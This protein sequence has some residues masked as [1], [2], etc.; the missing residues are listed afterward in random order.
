M[1]LSSIELWQRIAAEGLASPMQCRTWAAEAAKSLPAAETTDGIKV[2]QQLIEIGRLT[3]YQ[4][5]IL[6]GQSDRPLRRGSWHIL[7]RLKDPIWQ[8]WTEVT[9]IDTTKAEWDPP[10]W[11]RWLQVDDLDSLRASA[12]SL[13]RGIQMA[14][15]QHDHLQSVSIPELAD[16]ELHV[17]VGPLRGQVLTAQF[18][19]NVAPS[20]VAVQIVEQVASGLAALHAANLLHG[21][22]LPDRVFW[23]GQQSVLARDPLASWT[24]TLDEQAVGLLGHQLGDLRTASFLAPEFIA[25]GQPPTRCTDVYA[26]GCVW[27]W[28][29]T[30]KPPAI[31][32]NTQE[33]LAQQAQP[34]P[35]LPDSASL[36]EPM[37]KVLWH[38]LARN[39][40]SRFPDAS[41]LVKAILAAKEVIKLGK[42]TIAP[43]PSSRTNPATTSTKSHSTAQSGST[44]QSSSSSQPSTRTTKRASSRKQ[45]LSTDPVEAQSSVDSSVDKPVV[46]AKPV[47]SAAEKTSKRDVRSKGE[48]K[49]A[50]PAGGSAKT[51]DRGQVD[52]PDESAR[53]NE[54]RRDDE[55]AT[56]PQSS[57]S[58]A[59]T[60]ESGKPAET[61]SGDAARTAPQQAA[62]ATATD[63]A[64]AGR[65]GVAAGPPTATR[66]RPLQR[67]RRSKNK[68]MLPV[69][70]GAGFLI[71]LLLAL[72]FSGALDPADAPRETTPKP[73]PVAID[74]TAPGDVQRS[75]PRLDFYRIVDTEQHGLWAP[76]SAPSALPIDLLPPGGQCFVSL[77]P[78]E[79]LV[80]AAK[81]QLVAAFDPEVTRM[82]ES[83]SG[84]TGLPLETMAQVTVAF[85]SPIQSGAF[86]EW[87]VRVQLTQAQSLTQLKRQWSDPAAETV[88]QHQLLVNQSQ[89]AFYV[90]QQPLVDAQSVSTFSVGPLSLMRDVAELEGAGGPLV[91]QME[92]LWNATDRQA[93][94]AVL[95]APPYLFTEGRGLLA[96]SPPRLRSVL[97]DMLGQDMRAGLVQMHLEPSWYTELQLIGASDQ[98]AGRIAAELE[99]QAG[100]LP[101]EIEGWF[102]GQTPHAHWSRLALRYPQML[103]TLN[104]YSRFGVERGVA[105]SNAYLPT[106]AA[107][108]LLLASWIAMQESATLAGNSASPA[109]A[110][111]LAPLTVQQYLARPV[112]VSFAQEPIE[113]AWQM[114]GEEANDQL[115]AGT[116]TMRFELDG[117]AFELAG[118][119]RNQQL[120][121]FDMRNRPLREVLTQV[122]KMGN[123]VTTVTDT[124]DADQKLIWV[125]KADPQATGQSMISLTTRAAAT[126]SG[127]RLPEEFSPK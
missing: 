59:D 14:G 65:Q 57:G 78:A 108:N 97:R 126:G 75:D 89:L 98:D 36:P 67:R 103:R 23:D 19:G 35:E 92:T 46:A 21:R 43:A 119:T 105:I 13:P 87:A 39:P 109:D 50:K 107:H 95:F 29:L 127:D 122:T 113:V 71:V 18:A 100:Q 54:P 44:A 5:K 49:T 77:R 47:V 27:W 88:G 28:L 64:A 31:G 82:L 70:G 83:I 25:P 116:A 68:W 69:L 90:A 104:G 124:R 26:L 42:R 110:S 102:A 81:K 61:S 91:T 120:R 80:S 121:D 38:A 96:N 118:I 48:S 106:E 1:S 55:S 4:A 62:P 7:R 15:V 45:P 53:Q 3:N 16:G 32:A 76:P 101:S 112:T 6:A 10:G 37:R 125:I 123:P 66:R 93:D 2:L 74:P 99:Q 8:D 60:G 17:Q 114:I 40:A 56:D 94:L 111:Q 30:G 41:H 72:K 85:Y 115:P 24:A 84:A 117:D 33:T 63:Q 52:E 9:K 86:P 58:A 34:L 73:P 79:L 20:D 22:V 51:P 11:S 12:P